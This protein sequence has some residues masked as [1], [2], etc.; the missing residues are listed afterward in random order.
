[1]SNQDKQIKN[2][3]Q[4]K[5]DRNKTDD[6]Y[7][8]NIDEV[9]VFIRSPGKYL[10][11]PQRDGESST[12]QF[13]RDKSKRKLVTK[14]YTDPV[15]KEERQ[16]I[17]IEYAAL[18]PHCPEQGEKLLDVTKTLALQIETNIA[19]GYCLQEVTRHGIG[20]Q[21]RYIATAA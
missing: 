7:S 3:K 17:R 9:D 19:K 5:Q 15:T 6:D 13:I 20:P 12:Y 8:Q 2:G 16:Q 18:D 4:E 21:T 1:M 10:Q 11:L 14:S